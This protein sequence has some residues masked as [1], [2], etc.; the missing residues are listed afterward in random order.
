MLSHL[1]QV[2]LERTLQTASQSGNSLPL[3]TII[4]TAF[5]NFSLLSPSPTDLRH[6]LVSFLKSSSDNLIFIIVE[7]LA[8]FELNLLTNPVGGL[9]SRLVKVRLSPVRQPFFPNPELNRSSVQPVM[10]NRFSSGSVRVRTSSGSTMYLHV[11]S[12]LNKDS[13]LI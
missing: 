9:W 11:C 1:E 8:G 4:L 12:T 6:I 13:Y 5:P 10:P 3:E 2:C 7:V